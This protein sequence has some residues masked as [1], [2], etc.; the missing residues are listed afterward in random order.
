MPAIVA[1]I[2]A[3]GATL[4]IIVP[5]LFSNRKRASREIKATRE[6]ITNGHSEH[7]RETLDRHQ[8]ETVRAISGVE[9]RLSDRIEGVHEELRDI[10]KHGA[11][12]DGRILE[13]EKT[14][15]SSPQRRLARRRASTP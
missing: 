4:G 10:R 8:R 6:Q 5:L 3:T 13:L 1:M 2:G 9:T 15:P 12:Q 11:V 14:D 7:I